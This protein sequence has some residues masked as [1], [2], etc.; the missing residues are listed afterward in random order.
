MTD[1]IG[2]YM[3]YIEEYE[4]NLVVLES[5]IKRMDKLAKSGEFPD[6]LE[7]EN[8]YLVALI[9]KYYRLLPLAIKETKLTGDY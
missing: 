8:I 1:N 5:T 2:D 6:R 4:T 3:S 7:A 9:E